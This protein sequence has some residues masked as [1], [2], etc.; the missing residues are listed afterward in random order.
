VHP[1]WSGRLVV[2]VVFVGFCCVLSDVSVFVDCVGVEVLLGN[3]QFGLPEK[4]N[5]LPSELLEIF[6]LVFGTG[7]LLMCRM[8]SA[9]APT[10]KISTG[11][12]RKTV[13][14]V[15]MKGSLILP[16]I[17]CLVFLMIF[18]VCSFIIITHNSTIGESETLNKT[19]KFWLGHF[20]FMVCYG[21]VILPVAN[22]KF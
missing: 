8:T 15:I 17:C 14:R 4:Q 1:Y 2:A 9:L 12:A 20:L 3:G 21:N 13:Q 22:E 16:T 10:H 11:T 19:V 18:C 7:L 6:V 5:K